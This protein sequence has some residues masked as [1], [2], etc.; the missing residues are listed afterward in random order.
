MAYSQDDLPLR[1]YDRQRASAIAAKLPAF[2]QH[3]LAVIRAYEAEHEQRAVVLERI[4]ELSVGEPWSGYD[5]E[6]TET[7]LMTL[8]GADPGVAR[9]VANYEREHRARASVIKAAGR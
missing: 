3:E 5:D 9:Q 1:N 8:S 6:S 2:S 7:I 4:A